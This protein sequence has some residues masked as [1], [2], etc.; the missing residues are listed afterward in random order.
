[1]LAC[2]VSK[3][4]LKLSVLL[5]RLLEA[6]IK[7][8]HSEEDF[9]N[10]NPSRGPKSGQQQQPCRDDAARLA[11][12]EAVRVKQRLARQAEWKEVAE[13]GRAAV[14]LVCPHGCLAKISTAESLKRHLK[15]VHGPFADRLKCPHCEFKT[16]RQEHLRNHIRNVHIN[17]G[18]RD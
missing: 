11:F 6:H 7:T 12:N 9:A 4:L 13:K 18:V 14:G 8:K 10:P 16:S 1:V 15:Y 17:G 5:Q 2:L 3:V